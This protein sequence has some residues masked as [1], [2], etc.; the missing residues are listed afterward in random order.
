[1]LVAIA[2]IIG[3]IVCK[4]FA[5]TMT[6]IICAVVGFVLPGCQSFYKVGPKDVA[7]VTSFGKPVKAMTSGLHR[8][9]PWENVSIMDGAI[10]TNSF[11]KAKGNGITV[12]LGNM[13]VATVD[14]T[15]KW[16][17][18]TTDATKMFAD[19]RTFKNIQ[20]SLVDTELNTVLNDRF[21]TFDPMANLNDAGSVDEN[22]IIT[23]GNES[24]T[25][26]RSKI[27]N[28]ISLTELDIR[29][30]HFDSAT[31]SRLNA[32]QQQIA[33]TKIAQQSVL[34]AQ[35]KAQANN[36]LQSSLQNN[37]LALVSEC[38]DEVQQMI[39]KGIQVPV[40]YTC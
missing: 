11:T 6:A 8:K 5:A 2:C 29:V 38:Y 39:N 3:A 17:L 15:I 25:D 21:A 27:G 37:Q 12:R 33:E 16:R 7:I 34:T 31:Q 9:N 10:Q 28:S 14:V 20:D 22:K 35:N 18:E 23:I 30:V 24:L 40:G 19:Y 32:Y 4:S 26:M 1:V 36:T 13:T